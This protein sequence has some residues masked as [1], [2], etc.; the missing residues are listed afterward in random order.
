MS[1]QSSISSFT[2]HILSLYMVLER[3]HFKLYVIKKEIQIL[4]FLFKKGKNG[5]Q[6]TNEIWEGYGAN[7]VS[8]RVAQ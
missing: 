7:S 5:M 1:L 4:K 2:H 3:R 6:A 8:V